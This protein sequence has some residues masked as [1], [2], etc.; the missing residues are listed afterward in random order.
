MT[1]Y[2]TGSPRST[3]TG[4]FSLDIAPMTRESVHLALVHE[5]EGLHLAAADGLSRAANKLRCVKHVSQ[6]RSTT[7][8]GHVILVWVWLSNGRR[9]R[10]AWLLGA[11]EGMLTRSWQRI[12]WS[13][14]VFKS[15][16]KSR[17]RRRQ[18]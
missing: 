14:I 3:K 5:A 18:P 17:R 11:A 16:V 6:L 8:G 1:V 15:T 4:P 9:Y 10:V 7:R 12:P 2:L 13:D